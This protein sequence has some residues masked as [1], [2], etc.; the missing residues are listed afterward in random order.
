MGTLFCR[1]SI[2]IVR[3]SASHS[4]FILGDNEIR[5]RI[6]QTALSIHL[7]LMYTIAASKE[8]F[9]PSRR[10]FNPLS[11]ILVQWLDACSDSV[12]SPCLYSF[13]KL[14]VWERK[15]FF[16]YR[17]ILDLWCNSLEVFQILPSFQQS[18]AAGI[19]LPLLTNLVFRECNLIN[20]IYA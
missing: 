1:K 18:K 7:L 16:T 9:I 19:S 4:E 17:F 15:E 13:T 11:A 8:R 3:I 6:W 14:R 2:F 12:S 10:N 5:F 20:T